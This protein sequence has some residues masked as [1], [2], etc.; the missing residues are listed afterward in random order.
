MLVTLKIKLI[1]DT[2]QFKQ[3]LET[4]YV[5][6]DACNYISQIAFENKIF[7]KIK[8]QK[9][10]YYDVR[11][12]FGLSAQFVIRAISKVSESYKI[13]KKTQHSFKSTGS[14][15]YDQRLLSFKGLEF[16]SILTLQGRIL[17]PMVLGDYQNGIIKGHRVRGQADLV[18]I[19]GIFYF[20]IVIE[21]PD[22]SPINAKDFLGV[23]LGIKNIAVDSD[24]EIFS[25]NKVNGMRKRHAKLRAK[26][27][28][29][30]TKSS[31]RL[32]K[33]RS[34]KER[35]FA[36]DVNH[37]ISKSLVAKAKG[38]ERGIALED[39]QGIR[40]GVTVKK[41]QRRQHNS[42]SFYQLRKFV[43]YKAKIA[44]VTV[45]LVNPR[46]TSRTCPACGHIDKKNRPTR[47]TFCCRVCGCAGSADNIAAINI[48]RRAAANQP[49]AVTT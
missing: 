16:A 37:C 42:W 12:K 23:D 49:D 36:T 26:L 44:G 9:E 7:N 24:G 41:S 30:G 33:K 18:L 39:L 4:M 45:V 3:L 1:T 13:N 8:L 32:L 35:R 11:E 5:F 27:Q 15:I 29:K 19:D 21:L 47:D 20:L 6:N 10:C 46:N 22:G 31:K 17:V 2:K 38:T 28:K 14:I 25:G 40:E 43:E 48:G 34:K